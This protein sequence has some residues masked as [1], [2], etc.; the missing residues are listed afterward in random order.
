VSVCAGFGEAAGYL[1]GAGTAE[2]ELKRWELDVERGA[3]A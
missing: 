3:P 1:L 2:A